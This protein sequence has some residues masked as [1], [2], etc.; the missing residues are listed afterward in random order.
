MTVTISGIPDGGPEGDELNFHK[1]K[2]VQQQYPV[3]SQ[4]AK[5]A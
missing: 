4:E 1:G 2:K 5:L 3:N